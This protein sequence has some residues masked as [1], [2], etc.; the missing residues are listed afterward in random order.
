MRFLISPRTAASS[1]LGTV[2]RTSSQPASSRR[3]IS[4]TVASTSWVSGVVIDCTQMGLSPPTTTLP[5]RTSRVL[6]R[7]KGCW[8][9][10]V[11]NRLRIS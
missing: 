9:I 3:W 1:A 7:W 11:M 4:A 10:C 6:W 2:T 5:T 8:Y